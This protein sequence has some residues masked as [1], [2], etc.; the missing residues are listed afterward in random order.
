MMSL[1]LMSFSNNVLMVFPVSKHSF[2][3]AAQRRIG[4]TVKLIPTTNRRNHRVLV[5][6]NAAPGKEIR[7][8]FLNSFPKFREAIFL[9]AP[10]LKNK[11][12]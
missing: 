11:L 9:V 12:Q 8:C 7:H 4:R 3:F 10:I 5:Y 2:F 1:G 6:I